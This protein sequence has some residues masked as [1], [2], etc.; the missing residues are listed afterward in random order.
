MSAKFKIDQNGNEKAWRIFYKN[1]GESESGPEE[2]V[3]HL[4]G[5]I[6]KNELPPVS[7][8]IGWVARFLM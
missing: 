4:Q 2:V 6:V 3:W 1:V 5:V 8:N 7:S